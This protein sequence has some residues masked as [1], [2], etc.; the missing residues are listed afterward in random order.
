MK[1]F[2]LFRVAACVNETRVADVSF[3]C[4]SI[5]RLITAAEEEN[6]SLAVF[7]EL[8]V[9][10]FSCQDL[11]G[12]SL[13]LEKA[14]EGVKRIAD[15]TRGK[16]VTAV[17]GAPVKVAG[18]I[19]DCALVLRNGSVMGI[20]PKMSPAAG[21]GAV[22]RRMFSSSSI[23]NSAEELSG[24]YVD[25]GKKHVKEGF[26]AEARLV[27]Q[28]CNVSPSLLFTTGRA[29]IGIELQE[30][31]MTPF[32]NSMALCCAGADVIANLTASVETMGKAAKRREAV[33]AQSERLSCAY[34]YCSSG[35]GESTTDNVYGGAALIAETGELVEEKPSFTDGGSI[36][37]ADIDLERITAV[38]QR[39][40]CVPEYACTTATI[41]LGDAAKTDFSK[42][43]YREIDDAPFLPDAWND[44]E[45][46][47]EAFHIQ[48]QGLVARMK[49][50][51]C[52]KLT[53]GISGGLDSTM[54]L[55]VAAGAMDSLGLPHSNILGVTMPGLGTSKRT[56]NNAVDLMEA[57]GTSS[58]EIS[59]VPAVEQHFKDIEHDPSVMDSTYENAQARERTQ[60]LMDIANQENSIVVGTGDL[61]ELA[62]GW[63][64]YNGDHMSMYAVNA[65]VPKTLLRHMVT[66][67]AEEME[68][69]KPERGTRNVSEILYDVAATPISPELKP[70]DENGEIAQKT[71]DLIG[72]YELHDFFI[73]NFINYGYGPAK[74]AL[75][76]EKAF[77][78][79][80]DRETIVKWL[81]KFHWRFF[82]Q[83]FKRSCMPDGPA[84][85]SVS[86]SPRGSWMMPSDAKTDLWTSELE[87]L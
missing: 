24:R 34:I 5:C 30:D 86:F 57:L 85:T 60:I 83:Q 56:K 40:G 14:E 72:P 47:D 27:G 43:L 10:G 35:C 28:R 50:I 19:C 79:R 21:E 55:L 87:N 31:L 1:D 75:F 23:F 82:T 9:T 41:D 13:L 78:G 46:C 81:K 54:A 15:F 4:E 11:F 8:C 69:V 73:W 38:R 68:G 84:V 52:E 37:F 29:T 3:N 39:K 45:S 44:Y 36:I 58:R 59:V 64:T 63:C 74:L 65:S 16:Y 7:P 42:A 67:I 53:L 66:R 80:F 61:S 71:E 51:G 77:E 6:A 25:D 49:H 20:V 32:Q 12:Q 70:A 2:G 62:L 33:A 48:V 22:M 26:G 18:R 76:A 17:I